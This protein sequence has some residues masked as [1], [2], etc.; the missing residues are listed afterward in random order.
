M[1]DFALSP[2]DGEHK[3]T[4]CVWELAPVWHEKQAWL[5]FLSSSRDETAAK[6][7]LNDRFTGVA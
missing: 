2:R 4:Y 6:E 5:R 7:W 3:G 1:P